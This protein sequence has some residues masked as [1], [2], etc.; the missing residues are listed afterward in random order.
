VGATAVPSVPL[1]LGLLALSPVALLVSAWRL[2]YTGR[3]ATPA[4]LDHLWASV[5]LAYSRQVDGV[6]PVAIV[7]AHNPAA[8]PAVVSVSVRKYRGYRGFLARSSLLP[9]RHAPLNVRALRAGRR[10]RPAKESILGAVNG[11]ATASWQLPLGEQ[12]RLP[13]IRVRVDQAGL[14]SRL[15]TWRLDRCVMASTGT[16]PE[17]VRL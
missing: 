8:A 6:L 5:A 3:L 9:G 12:G 7:R 4:A 13:V 16:V 11:G 1:E 2:V 14:C 17:L 15:F 10:L